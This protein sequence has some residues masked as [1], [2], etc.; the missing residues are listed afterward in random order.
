MKGWRED[1]EESERERE[2]KTREKK[3]MKA[4]NIRKIHL[5]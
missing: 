4:T 2:R 1:G 3:E 5:G